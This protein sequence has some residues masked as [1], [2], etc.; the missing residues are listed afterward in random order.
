LPPPSFQIYIRPAVLVGRQAER[1]RIDELLER[2]RRGRSGTLVLRGE[3][4]IGK[5]SLLAYAAGAAR[6]MTVVR[7]RGV[8]SEASLAFVGLL[9][10]CR[11]LL[12]YVSELPESQAGSLQAALGFEPGEVPDRLAVG[13]ATLG[14]LAAA[15]ESQPILVLVDDAH[16]VD[17]PSTGAL[18]FA[19]R[20]LQADAV[21]ALFAVREGEGAKL[22]KSGLDELELVGLSRNDAAAIFAGIDIAPDVAERLYA[23]TGG[24]PLGLVELPATLT[25]AQ[26]RGDEPL[27]E[28][29]PVGMRVERAFH[30]RLDQLDEDDRKALVIAAASGSSALTAIV[31]AI[32]AAGGDAGALDRAEDAGLLRLGDRDLQFRHPLLR[33]AVHQTATPS[34]RRRAHNLLSD[35]FAHMGDEEQAAWHRA[36]AALGPD[37]AAAARLEE[38]AHNSRRRGAQ[39]AAAS[40]F[41]RAA[42]LTADHDL[43]IRRIFDAAESFWT[44]GQTRRAVELLDD[45]LAT[46]RDEPVRAEML[47]LRGHIEHHSGNSSTALQLLLDAAEEVETRDPTRA[48]EVLAE[49]FEAS[50]ASGNV[51]HRVDI[52][53]RLEQL[54]SQDE[55][56]PF[57]TSLILGVAAVMAGEQERGKRLLRRARELVETGS[58]PEDE[59]LLRWPSVWATHWL[60]RWERAH[61]LTEQTIARLR[62]QG[63]I[64]SLPSALREL[65]ISEFLLGSAWEARACAAEALSLAQDSGQTAHAGFAHAMLAHFEATRGDDD[66]CVAHAAEAIRLSTE[67]GRLGLRL[68]AERALG[69]LE[70]GHGRLDE[71]TERLARWRRVGDAHG[72]DWHEINGSVDLVEALVRTGREDEAEAVRARIPATTIPN[73]DALAERA[74]GLLAGDDFEKRFL[75]ALERHAAG[76]DAFEEARTRLC[77]GERLRRAGRRQEARAHLHEALSTFELLGARPWLERASAELAA[78]G[79]HYRRRDPAATEPLTPQ[80]LQVALQVAEG[81]ANRDVAAALFLSPKTVEFHLTRVY[82][83]LN[84]RSRAELARLLASTERRERLMGGG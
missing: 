75:T 31:T 72:L 18:L 80:E 8:E 14:L 42:E 55:S 28:P 24:N 30:G 49:A 54:A 22:E 62:A 84:V 43:R 36:A 32:E 41:E 77:F 35:A 23:V 65:A 13:A 58:G 68:S 73:S 56:E 46:V 61:Q 44:A 19:T 2:A 12:E 71:A 48:Q 20:R 29:L 1:A 4:G 39:A 63:R 64:A 6:G 9:D 53:A 10:V 81:K 38:V 78:T 51:E 25:P 59:P 45:G 79:E 82:R 26:L 15:A 17:E 5:T 34:E 67:F 66:A 76:Q 11:P 40:A 74:R 52:A 3:P 7:T 83:K 70:L 50:L 33:S 60:N 37:G 27:A 16:W 21:A 69:L 57:Y 47:W